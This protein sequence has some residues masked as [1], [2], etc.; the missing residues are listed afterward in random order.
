MSV[1]DELAA[2]LQ[3]FDRIR[4]W[5]KFHTPRNL[6]T[7]L[8]VEAAEITEIFQWDRE[9]PEVLS[10]ERQALMASEIADVATYLIRLATATD[11]DI[12]AAVRDKMALNEQRF[13]PSSAPDPESGRMTRVSIGGQ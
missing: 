9:N 2:E 6:A 13:P 11:V 7:A 8:A 12:I 4:G 3:E 10:P 5:A 1:L